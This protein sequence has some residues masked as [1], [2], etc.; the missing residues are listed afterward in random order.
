MIMKVK[1]NRH[2]IIFINIA[3]KYNF[4]K[5]GFARNLKHAQYGN[6]DET[7]NT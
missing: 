1:H 5:T 6:Q 3:R 7:G 4:I 2:L